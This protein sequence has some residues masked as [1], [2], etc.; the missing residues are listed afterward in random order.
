VQRW[1]LATAIG[2]TACG[3]A[4][5]GSA[6]ADLAVSVTVVDR[7][8]VRTESRSASCA[9]GAPYALGV[10][11]ERIAVTSD[12]LTVTD[13]HAHTARDGS[14]L[15]TSQ[16]VAG[17]AGQED[18]ALADGAVRTIAASSAA[19]DAIRITYSF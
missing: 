6:S 4:R 3:P 7:C 13:E 16:S 5:A 8:L 2:L 19:I 10:G 17:A 11:R 1:L 9:G 14:R 18:M 15:G 12:Q